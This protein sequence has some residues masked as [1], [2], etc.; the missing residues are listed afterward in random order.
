MKYLFAILVLGGYVAEKPTKQ[1]VTVCDANG[2]YEVVV[3]GA[4]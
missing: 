4:L 1:T 2:C 3:V